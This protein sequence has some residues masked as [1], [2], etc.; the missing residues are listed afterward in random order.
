MNRENPWK[1]GPARER[2]N[3]GIIE[4][5]NEHSTPRPL[6]LTTDDAAAALAVSPRTVHQLR[7]DGALRATLIG[8]SV[9]FSAAELARFVEARTERLDAEPDAEHAA[10]GEGV[11]DA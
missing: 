5:Q 3:A 4:N 9:R 8:R 10:E 1:T 7:R 11:G 2:G 6:L